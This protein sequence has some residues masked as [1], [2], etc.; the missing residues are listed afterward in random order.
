M[1]HPFLF[2]IRNYSPE[3]RRYEVLHTSFELFDINCGYHFL[4]E[5]TQGLWIICKSIEF[6]LCHLEVKLFARC[7]L[8]FARYS[9]VF[10][11]CS[12]L[13][14]RCLLVFT[15][16]SLRFA[17]CSLRS[18]RCSLLAT[19]CSLLVTFCSFLFVR[20]SLL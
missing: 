9:L 6:E 1:F 5:I 3:L 13:F 4:G 19:F 12:L 11:R 10:T 14:A 20:C 18:A 16:C 7:S 15:R 17:R 8:L 2:N